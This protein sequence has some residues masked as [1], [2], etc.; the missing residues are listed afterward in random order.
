[1]EFAIINDESII[2]KLLIQKVEEYLKN[3]YSKMFDDTIKLKQVSFHEKPDKNTIYCICPAKHNCTNKWVSATKEVL[4]V[5]QVLIFSPAE[6]YNNRPSDYYRDNINLS[7]SDPE[8]M[9]DIMHRIKLII[10]TKER[11]KNKPQKPELVDL[12]MK[13]FDNDKLA[14]IFSKTEPTK[15]SQIRELLTVRVARLSDTEKQNY[16]DLMSKLPTATFFIS[17]HGSLTI[18]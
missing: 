12:I 4:N 10:E 18:Q 13:Q 9:F 15:L 7:N 2:N 14:K 5:P 16:I 1:M 17:E 6:T 8:I 3:T 11:E